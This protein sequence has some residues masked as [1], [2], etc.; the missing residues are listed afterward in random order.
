MTDAT[1][2]ELQRLLAGEFERRGWEWDI[3]T[4]RRIVEEIV[5]RGAVDAQRLA[6]GV[7]RTYLQRVCATRTDLADAIE[8]AVGGRVPRRETGQ[9]T[10]ISNNN[11]NYA[12]NM[13]PGAQISGGAVNLGGT[14]INIQSGASRD[15]VLQAVG[16]LVQAGLSGDWNPQAAGELGTAIDARSD[17]ALGDVQGVVAEICAADE[18]DEGHVKKLLSDIA[19]QGLGGALGTG[20]SSVLGA[21]L[22]NPPF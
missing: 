10:L 7:P 5:G 18:P 2:A 22:R 20:I 6:Q 15:E 17:I 8:R 12:L 11:N 14:Q 4:G 1:S 21:L 3:A 9:A 13:G 16:V 19:T